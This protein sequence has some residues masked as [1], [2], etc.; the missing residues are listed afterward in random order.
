MRTQ[1]FASLII[2]IAFILTGG[3]IAATSTPTGPIISLQYIGHSCTLIIAPDGTRVINDPYGDH[4]EGLA[5]SRPT[6]CDVVTIS[7]FTLT[8]MMTPL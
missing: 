3:C 6:H 8:M 2:F 7:H 1:I 4:P 5:S